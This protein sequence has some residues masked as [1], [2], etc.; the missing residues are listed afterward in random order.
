[1]TYQNA[2]YTGLPDPELDSQFYENVPSRRLLAWVIDGGITFLLTV[3]VSVFTLTIGFWIFPFLWMIIGVIYR[4]MTIST[5]SATIG[6][7]IAGIEFRDRAGHRLTSGTAFF[8]T[9]IFTVASFT[10]V[11]QLLSLGMILMT[12]YHQSLSDML[13]GTTAINRPRD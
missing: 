3:L 9:V 1:M 8:H 2:T 4:T 11:L 13:L 7:R 5:A 12:R 10:L 6:M